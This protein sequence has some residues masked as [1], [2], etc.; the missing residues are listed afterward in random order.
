MI[1]IAITGGIAS[2]KSLVEE[3]LQQEGIITLDTDKVAHELLGPV[4]RKKLA[5]EVFA[6]EEKLRQLESIIHPKV[7]KAVEEFFE[8]NQHKEMVAVTVPLLYRANMQ[9][10][11]DFI[12]RVTADEN[13]RRQR[14]INKRN[15]SR[16][17]AEK[18]I[19][20]EEKVEKA[21][22]IVENNSTIDNL[23]EK[24][25]NILREIREQIK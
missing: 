23:R 5:E 1:K 22:F 8:K 16:E 20:A 2:G 4:D 18:R 12:I 6:D 7:K 11:F 24:V 15:L 10:M 13:I 19:K 17:D 21:D 3:F 14:L 25:K 9:D